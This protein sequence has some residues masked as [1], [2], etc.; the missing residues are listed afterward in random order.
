MVRNR[1]TV[2]VSGKLQ[3]IH[4][5][6]SSP[7]RLHGLDGNTWVSSPLLSS[8][9]VLSAHTRCIANLRVGLFQLTYQS[10]ICKPPQQTLIEETM[11]A[12][13]QIGVR[14]TILRTEPGVEGASNIVG[15]V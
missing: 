5:L 7:P 14:A 3:L 1:L 4:T 13:W 8:A 11:L 10:S 15:E 12:G 2:D 9:R 6:H